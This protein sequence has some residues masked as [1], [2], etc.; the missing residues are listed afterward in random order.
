[1]DA[2]AL[3]QVLV[4][5]A[6][7]PSLIK[8]AVESFV[9]GPPKSTKSS[10]PHQSGA[11]K[12]KDIH[13]SFDNLKQVRD[14]FCVLQNSVDKNPDSWQKQLQVNCLQWTI[15]Q[16]STECQ[17]I[18]KSLDHRKEKKQSQQAHAKLTNE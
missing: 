4:D 18:L 7:D 2:N 17:Q 8:S 15:D 12:I 11:N 14:V 13:R 1:M 3:S 6:L 16:L 10:R 5:E 9:S